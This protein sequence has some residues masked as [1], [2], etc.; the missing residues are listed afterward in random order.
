[1]IP[2][3]GQLPAILQGLPGTF[4]AI[5]GTPSLPAAKFYA[6]RLTASVLHYLAGRGFPE[7][8]VR[9]RRIGYAPVSSSHDLLVRQ[10][11]GAARSNGSQ[12]LRE[13]IDAGLVVQ[14]K[15]SAVR[16]FFASE[17]TGYI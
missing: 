2:V 14:D 13:A 7:Q 12:I 17:N 1:M 3:H 5:R 11:R 9:Q 10:I 6:G 15:T 4:F 8:F 16:D